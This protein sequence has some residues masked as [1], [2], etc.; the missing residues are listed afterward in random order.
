MNPEVSEREQFEHPY[1]RAL[2]GG[3]VLRGYDSL[4]AFQLGIV[5]TELSDFI[6]Y[7]EEPWEV[8]EKGL[9]VRDKTSSI[10][11]AVGLPP[12]FH[13]EIIA[14]IITGDLWHLHTPVELLIALQALD[15]SHS[16]LETMLQQGNTAVLVMRRKS[17]SYSA[18]RALRELPSAFGYDN[19]D[20]A[21]VLLNRPVLEDDRFSE[22][23]NGLNQ[24]HQSL[25]SLL[26]KEL[27][28][29]IRF[30]VISK[31][32]DERL[33]EQAQTYEDIL[34]SA[35]SD[36][37]QVF[38]AK[39]LSNGFIQTEI[40]DSRKI[41]LGLAGLSLVVGAAELTDHG[42]LAKILLLVAADAIMTAI[43]TEIQRSRFDQPPEIYLSKGPELLVNSGQ[44]LASAIIMEQFARQGN[45][46]GMA[47]TF[48]V[49]AAASQLTSLFFSATTGS[50]PNHEDGTTWTE[51]IKHYGRL[52][53]RVEISQAKDTFYELI[54]NPTT[55]GPMTGTLSAIALFL[56][57]AQTGALGNPSLLAL[58][59][60]WGASAESFGLA[61]SL[62]SSRLL[63]EF[64]YRLQLA[65]RY[66]QIRREENTHTR[67]NLTD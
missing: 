39:L 40:S 31:D 53:T 17:L 67:V 59:E 27:E 43:A 19:E 41:L 58:T 12:E 8:P 34:N 10:L 63:Q 7:H 46:P 51:R 1:L 33:M 20:F 50:R 15:G 14:N 21:D 35:I 23:Y 44:G 66:E 30:K 64:Q 28:K 5:R 52:P 38:S 29:P 16:E 9:G 49:S 36:F 18:L 37:S 55:L 11:K 26:T 54:K 6:G 61:G 65:Q 25:F 24:Y 45:L 60:M 48:S 42:L 3:E 56:Q 57:G 47:A 62:F 13:K 4:N 22:R 32:A 2:I